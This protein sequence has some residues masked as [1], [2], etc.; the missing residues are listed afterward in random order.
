M[1][2][3][4]TTSRPATSI[5]QNNRQKSFV[6]AAKYGT[7]YRVCL[8]ILRG[9]KKSPKIAPLSTGKKRGNPTHKFARRTSERTRQNIGKPNSDTMSK[10]MCPKSLSTVATLALFAITALTPPVP[11]ADLTAE[12]DHQRLMDLLHIKSLRQ[13]ADGRNASAPNAA[14]YDEVKA[15]PYPNLPDPLVLKNGKHVKSAKDWWQKRP[16]EI[17][18]DFDR[19]V[20]GRVPASLPAVRWQVTDTTNETIGSLAALTKH[21]MGH[22][23]N[24]AYPAITVD[25]QLTLTTPAQATSPVPVI[26]EFT[27]QR[28]P[29]MPPMPAPPRATTQERVLAQGSG[30][31]SLIP[32]SIQPDNGAGLTQGIIGLANKGQPRGLE[33][34]GALRAWAWGASRALDYFETDKNVDAKHVAIAGHSRYGK[35]A[36][37]TMAYDARFASGYISS[38]GE[39]GAKLYRRNWGE[40]VENVA[41]TGEYH[42]MAGNFLK[43]AGPLTWNDLPVDSHELI[44]LCAP[45]PVFIGAGA[46]QGDGWVD[47]KGM[48]MAAVGAGPVYTLLGRKGLGTSEFPPIE[49]PLVDGDV[50]FRQH[51]QGHTPAPN[52]PFFLT[53]A[54]RYFPPGAANAAAQSR[55]SLDPDGGIVWNVQPG[56]AHQDQIEMSGRKVS[57]IATYGV[58][59]EAHLILQ[60]QVVFPLLRTLP[61][62]T[63]ASLIYTFG[64]DATPRI[65]IDGHAVAGET[66]RSISHKGILTIKSVLGRKQDVLLTRTL[67]PS[68]TRQLVIERL[69]FTNN[70]SVAQRIEVE[71][72]EKIAHT[73]PRNGVY[74]EYILAARLPDA[75]ERTL[76][77]GENTTFS[78]VFTGRNA[79][80]EDAS[81]D[82]AAEESARQTL[83][84]GYL[85]KL[86]L[87]T[88]DPVLNRAFAFAKIRTAESVYETKGGLMHGPGGG[89]YYAAIWANDQA[90]YANPFFPFLG[91]A[92]ANASAVNAFRLFAKYMN[93]DYKPIPTSIIAEGTSFW[94]GA[95]DRGD[96]A[97]IAYGAARF[98]LAYGDPKTA[99]ELWP[100]IEWCLEYCNRKKNSAG[101]IASDSDEL[102]GRFPAGKA[103]LN[104]SSLYYDA[105]NSA[106]MLGK[107][108]RNVDETQ[109]SHYAQQARQVRAAIEQYFG[110]DID[111]FH[112]YRYYDGNTVLRAWIC[113]PLTVGIFD[114][115]SGTVEAL[116]SP[117]LWTPDGLAT[118]AGEKTFWDRAS[119]YGLR[120][121]LAAG[122]TQRALS[123]LTYYSTRRLLGEHVPYP[124]EAWPE[125]NQRHLAA[126]SALYCRIYTEG[127]FGIRPTGLRSF[128]LT[129]RLPAGWH[130][131]KLQSVQAFGH[132]FDLAVT[133]DGDKLRVDVKLEGQS[134]PSQVIESGA[135]TSIRFT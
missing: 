45:R 40:L 7:F 43:Y 52:L 20:Y 90:E 42:W 133:R 112:T 64:E 89:S 34:W 72:T 57:L 3:L 98:A 95:G 87:E 117:R 105:L 116:F 124:V 33:D 56:E 121:A 49:T 88:P 23:D 29:G 68:T 46:T 16:P 9:G 25:I 60:R 71:H 41:G 131:M 85:S 1:T 74:G 53:F 73:N 14:N 118:Q 119:L 96:M 99:L 79:H 128:D 32:T 27:F 113:T 36:L 5:R 39:A 93:P 55:W 58:D 63:H 129:P 80:E 70:S 30:Y 54:A 61:N 92:T 26:T 24:S 50:A 82:T 127:L 81:V 69:T 18:E 115:A 47:A 28:R 108:L 100:L 62:D 94:N 37:I 22:V 134:V 101:V 35:A 135:T 31:A 91:D 4:E 12:Q 76:A 65:L 19:E 126:E 59:A 106:V 51:T 75:G 107:S 38:S 132:S 111:G 84:A 11:A 110:A 103:N 48:F 97:M 86:V 120:G 44:A 13:G 83:V 78:L 77:P 130:E 114:R 123:F 15:N 2:K 17:V 8:Y 66:V 10:A 104:T 67:F 6:R 21:L 122:E 102:E 125:G 109:L